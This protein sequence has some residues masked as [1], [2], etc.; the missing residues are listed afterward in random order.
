[1][2]KPLII[3]ESPSKAKTI[4]KYL[5]KKYT[6]IASVGHVK[7]LPASKLGIEIENNFN[8]Q[9]VTIKG[10]AKVL[11]E[12]KKAAKLASSVFLAPDPDREGEAIAWHIAEE[13]KDKKE[14]IFRVLF[15][16]I[17]E[18]A[19][20]ESLLNPGRI[21]LNK[22]NAQQARRILDR[23]VGYKLSPLLWDKVRRGLSAGRVQSVAVRLICDLEKEIAQFVSKEYWTI[24]AMVEGRTPPPFEI[25]LIKF[26]NED[27]DIPDQ[28]EAE[29]I[30]GILSSGEYVVSSIEKKDKKRNPAAP[31]TTSKLQQEAS[32]K[33]R[34]TASRTMSI[35]QKLYEGIDIGSEG[36]AGLITYMRT[37]SVRISKDAQT[38]ARKY[39]KNNFGNECLPDRAIEY[40]NKK[41]IQDAH[42][43]IR[44]TSVEYT[45]ERI[46]EYVDRDTY[47]LY[48]LI[49]NRFVACQ[50][51]PAVFDTITVD[52]TSGECLLRA[53]GSAVKFAGFMKVYQE[54]REESEQAQD[55]VGEVGEAVIPPLTEGERLN[56]ISLEPAQHFTQPPS[57]YTEASL[58]KELEEKGI[59]RPSTYAAIIYTIQDREYVEKK[60][61]KFFPTELGVLVNDLLVEHFP[62]LIDVKFTAKMEEDLDEVEEGSREWR[63]AV[64]EFYGPFDTH[65]EKA[66]K[67]MRNLKGEETPTDIKCEKCGNNMIIKWGKLGYFLACS[68]YPECKNTKEFR[69]G[70]EGKI[71]VVQQET[72]N[73]I[74]PVCSSPMVIKSGRFGRFLA[75]SNYPTCKTTKPITTGVKCPEPDCKGEITEKRSKRGKV[76]YS[77]T[78]YPACKFA[79][80]D[81]PVAQP[82]PQCGAPF[83]VEKR[84]RSG[85]ISLACIN[86][87]CGYKAG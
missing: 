38:D 18:K 80:W 30:K 27:I 32:K 16:E 5:G 77:C 71:E 56:L 40:R 37:D 6:V 83:L 13:L 25:R 12:I 68:G 69:R 11:A 67:D 62:E 1:M 63:D 51:S 35:A 61:G 75:C 78:K 36:P 31:F 52:V 24:S 2:S 7:D 74:C 44:P 26:R 48:K 65:L 85:G 15:N 46:K 54:E 84:Q 72:T 64:G 29:R 60:E 22:V 19:I 28:Q 23:I 47:N 14:N 55:G 58:I 42:E 53:T 20:K 59:G 81:K 3:V 9:Y 87:E 49:W 82:C 57:R 43:A 45:P 66:K 34:F 50:M 41:G 73:E 86:K 8:P 17:T 79:S 70:E 33:L 39:I 10:K 21:D 4:T 76:F